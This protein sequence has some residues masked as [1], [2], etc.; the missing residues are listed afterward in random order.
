MNLVGISISQNLI[1]MKNLF[2]TLAICF[3]ASGA[4]ATITTTNFLNP[5]TLTGTPAAIVTNYGFPLLI[6]YVFV[7]NPPSTQV[8]HSVLT[9]TND[10]LWN[11]QVGTSA[12]SNQMTTVLTLY[13]T[14]NALE[15]IVAPPN[16][17]KIA[18]YSQVQTIATNT[19]TTYSTAIFNNP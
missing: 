12:N 9:T 5:T 11:L 19:V 10:I 14:T 13:P 6:G 17:T 8:Y 7:P 1:N 15:T 16:T 3:A 2:L 18:L 4:R